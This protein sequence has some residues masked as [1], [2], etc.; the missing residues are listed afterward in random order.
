MTGMDYR[1]TQLAANAVDVLHA[2]LLNHRCGFS[3][4]AALTVFNARLV[5]GNTTG[6]D[7]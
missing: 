2:A 1:P 7:H 3:D 4:N 6:S 5:V